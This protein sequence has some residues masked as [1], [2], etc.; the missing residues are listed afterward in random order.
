MRRFDDQV[1]LITGGASGIGVAIADRLASEGAAIVV[2]DLEAGRA[3]AVA[4][5]LE[6]DHG[7]ATLAL[8]VDLSAKAGA[9]TVIAATL[10]RF[11]RLDVLVNNAGGGVI[12]PTLEHT[13]DTMRAT[14][15]RNLWTTIWCTVGVIPPMLERGYGRTVNVGAESVRNGLYD[16]AIYNAAKGGVHAMC[17]ALTREFASHGLTF[18]TVAPSIVMTAM[19]RAALS[20]E[21]ASGWHRAVDL[22]PVGRPATVEEVA[23]AVAYLASAEA[24]FIT[25]QVLSVNG[26]SSMG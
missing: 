25:G 22:I 21:D 12:M 2:V 19:V 1:A 24:G 5:T 17:S 14:I 3:E 10:D 26:G 18:N 11:A 6:L 23:S 7:G 15:D 16:H 8:G 9:D 13:E 20:G 4:A